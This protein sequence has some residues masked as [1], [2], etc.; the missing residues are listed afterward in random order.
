MLNA[1]HH[2]Q[3]V[4]PTEAGVD[5]AGILAFLDA[6]AEKGRDLHSILLVRGGKAVAEGYFA[7]Y[8]PGDKQHV[9]SVSKSWT[10][11]A[12]GLASDEGRLS[13]KDKVISFFPEKLPAEVSENLAD[14]EVRD[15]LRMGTGHDTAALPALIRTADSDWAESFLH[16]PVEHRPGSK[17]VY[18]SGASYML[19]AIVQKVT[20]EDLI[21]YL[22]PRLFEPLGI[23]GVCW[24]R[25]PQGI[26]CGG[27]GI[28]V[29]T[30]DIAKL[31][32]L[33]LNGGVVDGKRILSQEWVREAT[34]PQIDNAPSSDSP[35]WKQG[36]GYQIWRCQHGCFRFDGAYGQY[37]V[38][39]PEQDAVLV[40]TSFVGNMQEVL[41][42][43]WAYLLPALQKAPLPASPAEDALKQRLRTLSCPFPKGIGQAAAAEFLCGENEFG[44]ESLRLTS[45]EEGGV[46]EISANGT[47]FRIPFGTERYQTADI[48][49][50]PVYPDMIGNHGLG[51]AVSDQ[52]VGASGC[53]TDGILNLRIIYR[54]TPHHMDFHLKTD[55]GP[56][57][58]FAYP[59]D[60]FRG[61][62][63]HACIPLV[64]IGRAAEKR[65]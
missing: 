24:D 28:H 49:G 63:H 16:W 4:S 9:F 55:G 21:T 42:D 60:N 2:F 65:P 23:T 20:G 44:L 22:T 13:V 50:F 61:E 36:Y 56:T 10:S 54:G 39:F 34:S 7:P 52:P 43:V 38:A 51:S 14:M 41:D 1:N 29:S 17:F 45:T 5:P 57:L 35:D 53:W 3:A 12:V 27:W 25:S 40:L 58:S 31:G 8:L 33:Y 48:T 26:C 62:D 18:N 6:C 32:L 47:V 64:S 37:M 19:S 15:L 59:C 30:E 11:T 46:I